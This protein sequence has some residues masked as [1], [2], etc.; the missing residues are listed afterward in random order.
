MEGGKSHTSLDAEV[1][2]IYK[3]LCL[4]KDKN[5]SNLLIET[6]CET[7]LRLRP[8]SLDRDHPLKKVLEDIDTL[9][10]EQKCVLVHTRRDGN[11]CADVLAHLGGKQTDECVFLHEPPSM[12]L[13][14]LLRDMESAIEFERNRQ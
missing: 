5:L 7:I 3:G 2:S 8:E 11:Q 12:L 13:P 6:D 9:K 4:I 14:Y 1:W 10:V